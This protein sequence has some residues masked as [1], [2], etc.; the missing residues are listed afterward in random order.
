M[1]K[2]KPA[3]TVRYAVPLANPMFPPEITALIRFINYSK[4]MACPICHKATRKYWTMLCPFRAVSLTTFGAKD[5]PQVFT[6]GEGVC[7]DHPIHEIDAVRDMLVF[8]NGKW[9][10]EL[11]EVYEK[12]VAA[13]KAKQAKA[14][15]ET[16]TPPSN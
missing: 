15:C 8:P 10:A 6:P 11:G 1:K 9:W 16:I 2:S 12:T 4:P 14:K 7:V 13:H 3:F 5:D